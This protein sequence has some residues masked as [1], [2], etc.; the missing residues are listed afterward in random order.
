MDSKFLK[1]SPFKLDDFFKKVL[2]KFLVW[3]E[4]LLVMYGELLYWISSLCCSTFL[5]RVWGLPIPY[6]LTNSCCWWFAWEPLW[7][8]MVVHGV[9]NFH[10]FSHS[11][12][13]VCV[14]F[15]FSQLFLPVVNKYILIFYY[16]P[17]SPQNTVRSRN[18]LLSMTLY[19]VSVP[20]LSQGGVNL[21]SRP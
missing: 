13:P 21:L 19:W 4:I 8:Y 14:S 20:E 7:V 6:S 1:T 9:F 5:W 17:K 10:F 11:L 16:S 15:L 18:L 3:I 2:L 12:F